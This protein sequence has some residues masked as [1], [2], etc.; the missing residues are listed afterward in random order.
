MVQALVELDALVDEH[1]RMPRFGAWLHEDEHWNGWACPYFERE[2]SERL[3]RAQL[4]AG[5]HGRYDPER[6]AYVFP[7]GFDDPDYDP[8]DPE[9][10]GEPDWVFGGIELEGRHVYPIG[11]WAWTWSRARDEPAAQANDMVVG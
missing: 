2:E 8:N 11:S 6:D 9:W 4:A 7:Y 3:L 10:A 1:G 5:F